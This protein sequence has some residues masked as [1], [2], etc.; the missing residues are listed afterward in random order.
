LKE[1]T[2]T[3]LEFP[4]PAVNEPAPKASDT[5]LAGNVI[6]LVLAEGTEDEMRVFISKYVFAK[7]ILAFRLLAE[8]TEAAGLGSLLEASGAPVPGE[9]A[10][11]GNSLTEGSDFFSVLLQ[12]IPKALKEGSL[13]LLRFIGLAGIANKELRR[14][15]EDESV[16][17]DRV[18]LSRGR[19][20]AYVAEI[21]EVMEIVT[22]AMSQMGIDKVIGALRPL[23]ARL[24]PNFQQ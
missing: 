2:V 11:E 5:L 10:E 4:V 24:L 7:S 14:L 3:V 16:S 6:E 8:F 19:D 9:E 15:E 17:L 20:I 21:D 22:S 1:R 13:P 18:L 12:A 23:L